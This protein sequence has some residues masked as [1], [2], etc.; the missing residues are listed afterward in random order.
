MSLRAPEARPEEVAHGGASRLAAVLAAGMARL[1]L[2]PTGVKKGKEKASPLP[3][4]TPEERAALQS[5]ISKKKHEDQVLTTLIDHWLDN[6]KEKKLRSM[7][8][9]VIDWKSPWV[10]EKLDYFLRESGYASKEHGRDQVQNRIRKEVKRRVALI[11]KER[12]KRGEIDVDE[13]YLDEFAAQDSENP[14][15]YVDEAHLLEQL[16]KELGELRS[17]ETLSDDL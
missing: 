10:A 15:D 9:N 5:L 8:P 1:S 2:L 17:R 6:M 4:P 16:D 3:D 14:K 7:M 12:A 13:G 11:D